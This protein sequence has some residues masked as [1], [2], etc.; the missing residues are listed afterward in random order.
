MTTTPSP[1]SFFVPF[2]IAL[3]INRN[4]KYQVAILVYE[5]IGFSNQ[6]WIIGWD[7]SMGHFLHMSTNLDFLLGNQCS[8]KSVQRRR[9]F[10]VGLLRASFWKLV[11]GIQLFPW[12][13]TKS[14]YDK[15]G[16]KKPALA[17]L[18]AAIHP[19]EDVPSQT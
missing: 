3:D 18:T 10:R 9:R 19:F 17:F 12:V 15:G 16:N 2:L 14:H 7:G 1:K 13:I 6:P 5:S 4:Q 8:T 11:S